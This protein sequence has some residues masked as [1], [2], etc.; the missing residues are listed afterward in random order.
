MFNSSK[1]SEESNKNQGK[2]VL[3]D[4]DRDWGIYLKRNIQ[5]RKATHYFDRSLETDPH[6]FRTLFE[7]SKCKLKQSEAA[8]AL[9]QAKLCVDRAASNNMKAKFQYA[10]CLAGL[11]EIENA[12]AMVHGIAAEHP[13]NTDVQHIKDSLEITL[14]RTITSTS[15]VPILRKYKLHLKYNEN[16]DATNADAPL[17]PVD[18]HRQRAIELMKHKLYFD[19]T[20]AE[21]MEFWTKLQQDETFDA[22]LREIIERITQNLKTHENMLYTREPFY[23]KRDRFDVGSLAKAQRRAFYFAQEETQREAVWQLKNIKHLVN[24]NFDAALALTERVLSEFY[25]IKTR[26]VFPAK[27]EFLC[28]LCKLI[29]TRYQQIY[30]TIPANLMSLRV[31]DRLVALFNVYGKMLQGEEL[32]DKRMEYFNK[33]LCDADYDMEKTY[34]YHQLSEMCFRFRRPEESQRFARDTLTYANLCKSNIW[35]FLAYFNIIR[36]DAIKQNYHMM[37]SDLSEMQRIADNLDAFTQ[38]FANTAI[39]SFDDIQAAKH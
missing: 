25:V 20:F 1:M 35:T 13:T 31:E 30:R 8:E 6:Q 12:F 22:N 34:L 10:K 3:N 18:L 16:G 15:A 19:A 23:A 11:N 36:V 9:N 21:Q 33:R 38:V 29:G 24:S 17:H 27:F 32:C 28:Q 7:S 37:R 14:R 2:N 5:Y 26:A 39:R 4:V